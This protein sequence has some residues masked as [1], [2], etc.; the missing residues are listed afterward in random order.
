M[1]SRWQKIHRGH[2][3][4]RAP[5]DLPTLHVVSLVEM[6]IWTSLEGPVAL[7]SISLPSI[8]S[9]VLRGIKHGP[10]SLFTAKELTD[11]PSLLRGNRGFAQLDNN[12]IEKNCKPPE[13][14]KYK[15]AYALE[16]SSESSTSQGRSEI[17]TRFPESVIYARQTVEW[18]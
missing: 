14:N 11:P 17:E 16:L 2:F 13:P 18:R 12:F 3:E 5:A 15:E 8:F 10:H 9:L 6:G 4:R 7:V 1:A